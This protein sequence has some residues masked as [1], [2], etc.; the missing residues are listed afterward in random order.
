MTVEE[1]AE[2]V[3]NYCEH[4]YCCECVLVTA[5]WKHNLHGFNGGFCLDIQEA[6]ED[7]LDRALELIKKEEIC[8]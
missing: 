2:M 6:D 7:E 3:S 8:K 1:K 4:T 5:D